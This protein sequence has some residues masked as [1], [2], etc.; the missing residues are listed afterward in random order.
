[1]VAAVPE[2]QDTFQSPQAL[3]GGGLNECRTERMGNSEDAQDPRIKKWLFERIFFF[4]AQFS[5]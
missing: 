5:F 2:H 1:M 3:E 4:P